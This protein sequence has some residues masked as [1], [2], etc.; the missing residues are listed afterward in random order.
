MSRLLPRWVYGK[1][2]ACAV[3]FAFLR[4]CEKLWNLGTGKGDAT[5]ETAGTLFRLLIAP[6]GARA[7][8]NH[9]ECIQ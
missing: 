5:A 7:Q 8:T 4:V 2:F 9:A 3:R 6:S 1:S